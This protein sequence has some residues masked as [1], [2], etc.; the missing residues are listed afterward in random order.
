LYDLLSRES[1]AP[2]GNPLAFYSS[3]MKQPGY[4][5]QMLSP[6]FSMVTN[7]ALQKLVH[8]DPFKQPRTEPL[9]FRAEMEAGRVLTYSPNTIESANDVVVG[10]TLKS[11]L[12]EY[13]RNRSNPRLV[14]CYVAD[15]FHKYMTINGPASEAQ[16]FSW[17]RSF[18]LMVTVAT[19]SVAALNTRAEALG[20]RG[21]NSPVKAM[22]FNTPNKVFFRT[23]DQETQATVEAYAGARAG[24]VHV[25]SRVSLTP[26][27]KLKV[28]ASYYL[29]GGNALG[30]QKPMSE[31]MAREFGV[32]ASG[33]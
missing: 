21:A 7:A 3:D 13:L 22:L 14:T 12:A 32:G 17:G 30:F 27:Y 5:L 20:C 25:P 9:S 29:A 1:L 24:T 19:Q 4:Y 33:Q 10:N 16:I 31:E 15:E 18:R 11:L 26:V 2:F 23:S 6:L 28:G 8:L